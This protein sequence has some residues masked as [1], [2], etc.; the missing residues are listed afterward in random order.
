LTL[1]SWLCN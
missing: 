1:V